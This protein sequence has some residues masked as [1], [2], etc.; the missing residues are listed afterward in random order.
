MQLVKNDIIAID[1]GSNQVK[2]G[3]WIQISTTC[4]LINDQQTSIIVGS[5][6]YT[7]AGTTVLTTSTMVNWITEM[8][9]LFT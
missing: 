1:D 3:G 5:T 2:Y 4:H 9:Q 6:H 7:T 8:A